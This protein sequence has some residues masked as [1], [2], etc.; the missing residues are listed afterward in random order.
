MVG[1]DARRADTEARD[2]TKTPSIG[3]IAVT[4]STSALEDGQQPG[5][6][7]GH[8]RLA[9]VRRSDRGQALGTRRRDLQDEPVV[10]A[11]VGEPD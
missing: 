9:G 2:R 4:P 11:L 6:P 8:H 7:L 3:W 1:G 5:K 10:A